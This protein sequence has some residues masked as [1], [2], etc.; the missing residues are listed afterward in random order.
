MKRRGKRGRREGW[1]WGQR[2]S[3]TK[4][5]VQKGGEG[6]LPQGGLSSKIKPDRKG[7][8]ERRLSGVGVSSAA[9]TWTRALKGRPSRVLGVGKGTVDKAKK[10]VPRLLLLSVFKGT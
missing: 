2:A 4:V 5:G 6:Q 8:V 3:P 9:W 1:C 7:C 10:T